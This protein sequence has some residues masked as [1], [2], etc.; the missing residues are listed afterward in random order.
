VLKGRAGLRK[1]LL[2]AAWSSEKDR[3]ENGHATCADKVHDGNAV[4]LQGGSDAVV[5]TLFRGLKVALRTG[6]LIS[7]LG[8]LLRSRGFAAERNR[9]ALR[10]KG[11]S[12]F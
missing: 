1:N 12:V 8:S 4:L 7:T 5:T 2:D 3:P 11:R 10:S 9:E 6:S